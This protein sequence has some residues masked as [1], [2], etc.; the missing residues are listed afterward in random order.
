MTKGTFLDTSY[1]LAL[2]NAGDA[3]HQ[4]AAVASK[5][6]QPPYVTTEA[7]LVEVGNAFSGQ[8]WRAVGAK[9][10]RAL[11]AD[12]R[13]EVVSVDTALF[14]RALHLYGTRP[15]KEWG[16]TDCISFVVMRE[17]GM[18]LALTTDKHFVQAGFVKL[19]PE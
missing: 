16:M 3:Y 11:Q 7:V 19:L 1:I 15:D 9:T 5:E 10:I 6:V 8:Q 18:R 12:P 2:F 14:E 13:V 4:R 17:R